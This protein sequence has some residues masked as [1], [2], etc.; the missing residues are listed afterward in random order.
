MTRIEFGD[1]ALHADSV[2]RIASRRKVA[3][4]GKAAG[5]TYWNA[6]AYFHHL[7]Q[8]LDFLLDRRLAESG[9]QNVPAAQGR[10]EA[11]HDGGAGDAD[12]M[13][14]PFAVRPPGAPWRHDVG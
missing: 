3:K 13:R 5:G 4:S 12:G 1:W 6:Q 8:A 10:G 14:G 2:Q 11:L 7:H 9:A